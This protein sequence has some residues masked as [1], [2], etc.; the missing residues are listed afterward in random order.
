MCKTVN[1]RRGDQL[2]VGVSGVRFG[3]KFGHIG[4][5]WDISVTFKVQFL[6]TDLIK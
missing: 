6:K 2:V 1:T 4:T 3:S 5:N